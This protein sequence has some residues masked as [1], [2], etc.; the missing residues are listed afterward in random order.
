MK[1]T[2]EISIDD[3]G[4][5]T[6]THER[7]VCKT[8]DSEGTILILRQVDDFPV[9]TTKKSIAK[10]RTKQFGKR[11]KFQLEEN[12]PI[13]FLGLAEDCNGVDVKKISNSILMS[14]GGM[15]FKGCIKRMSKHTDGTKNHLIV[16]TLAKMVRPKDTQFLPCPRIAQLA[17]TKR[18]VSRKRLRNTLSSRR[19]SDFNMELSLVN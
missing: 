6:T 18:K 17:S 9:G 15:S 11:V 10:R 19:K 12:P 4:F 7:C 1:P 16:L 3:L 2:D 14:S 13:T 5:Q 8:T